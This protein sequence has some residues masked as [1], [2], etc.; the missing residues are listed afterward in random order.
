MLNPG[1]GEAAMPTWVLVQLGDTAG[2]RRLVSEYE[3]ARE[4]TY[5][6]ADALAAMYASL[7]DS[8]RALQLLDEAAEERAFTLV[9]LAN[10]PMF[11][12]LHK[13]ARFRRLVDGIGVVPPT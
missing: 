10:Y 11:N 2:A 8:T 4:H 12:S 7:G 3:A 5:V 6:A 13:S 9:F 1:S